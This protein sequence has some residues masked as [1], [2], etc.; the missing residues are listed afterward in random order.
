VH[1][2]PVALPFRKRSEQI[3]Q[4]LI[5]TLQKLRELD[6]LRQ[7]LE[8]IL[9]GTVPPTTENTLLTLHQ[10]SN[11][12]GVQIRTLKKHCQRLGIDPDQPLRPDA[13]SQLRES[14]AAARRRHHLK[15]RNQTRPNSGTPRSVG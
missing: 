10:A 2:A 3:W 4:V 1:S 7:S 9:A 13:L 6:A 12:L 11:T 8:S 14:L 15:E 5:I